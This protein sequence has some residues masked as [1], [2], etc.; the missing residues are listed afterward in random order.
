M[1]NWNS[2]LGTLTEGWMIVDVYFNEYHIKTADRTFW[3][4][5]DCGYY[6]DTDYVYYNYSYVEWMKQTIYTGDRLYFYQQYGNRT[7]DHLYKYHFDFVINDI[8]DLYKGGVRGAFDVN[9][10]FYSLGS[11]TFEIYI[12]APQDEL[13]LINFNVSKNFHVNGNDTLLPEF[14]NYYFHL[15]WY[16]AQGTLKGLNK[17]K[18]TNNFVT[19]N[20]GQQL[21]FRVNDEIGLIYKLS[22]SEVSQREAEVKVAL[23][24]KIYCPENSENH[25]SSQNVSPQGTFT[26][27]IHILEKPTTMPTPTPSVTTSE[28]DS[29]NKETDNS[30]NDSEEVTTSSQDNSDTNSHETQSSSTVSDT[31]THQTQSSSTNNFDT[32]TNSQE[33]QSSSNTNSDTNSHEAQSSSVDCS[34]KTI[35]SE[36]TNSF[37]EKNE[38]SN[39]IEDIIHCIKEDINNLDNI[40]NDIHTR[41]CPNYTIH[42]ITDDIKDIIDNIEEDKDYKIIGSD[43]VAQIIHIDSNENKTKNTTSLPN[44]DFIECEKYFK[45]SS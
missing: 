40:V 44:F 26:F 34:I 13:E 14:T 37:S 2:L 5:K 6:G 38:Y 11:Q 25:C 42:E 12:Y 28:T 24:A 22:D 43:F 10:N 19:L 30:S 21:D 35:S 36:D 45:K 27:K 15:D 9:Q 33:T 17:D 18:T 7:Q 41:I 4:C 31:N 20:W 39:N 1:L 32:N 23:I 16:N 29:Q 3:K 8:T